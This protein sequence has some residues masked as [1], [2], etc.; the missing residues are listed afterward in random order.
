[1][2]H[3]MQPCQPLSGTVSCLQTGI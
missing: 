2:G 3:M 1:M